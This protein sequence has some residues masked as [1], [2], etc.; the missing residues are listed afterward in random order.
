MNQKCEVVGWDDDPIFRR[1]T[2]AY[3]EKVGYKVVEAERTDWTLQKLR[4]AAPI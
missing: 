4:D 2:G 3:L 1:I